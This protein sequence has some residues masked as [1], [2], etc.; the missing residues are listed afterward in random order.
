MVNP[1]SGHAPPAVRERRLAGELRLLSN[2]IRV[3]CRA[4]HG[5]GG[6]ALCLECAR[7]LEYATARLAR[8]PY[9]P[10]PKCKHCPTHCY[11]SAE[12]AQMK[13]VMRF[14]GMWYVRH[15][16]LDWLVRYFMS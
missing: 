9:D 6:G 1:A 15:G 13:R 10:K 2:F 11:R 12:R 4:H 3:Y 7:L 14:S 8:C 16:R 5:T